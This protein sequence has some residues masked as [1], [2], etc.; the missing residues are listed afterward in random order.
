[1]EGDVKYGFCK[2][3]WRDVDLDADGKLIH[4]KVSSDWLSGLFIMC[5]GSGEKPWKAPK[6]D[7]Q[8]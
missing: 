6:D 7:D 3:C 5:K 1:M 2:Y 4:H 8:S